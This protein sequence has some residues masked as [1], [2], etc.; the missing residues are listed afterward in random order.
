[1]DER[2]FSGT[3][4]DFEINERNIELFGHTNLPL[5]EGEPIGIAINFHGP[6]PG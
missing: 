6:G 5:I 1:M 4:T 3:T 2:I